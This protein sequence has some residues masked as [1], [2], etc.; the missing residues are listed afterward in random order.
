MSKFNQSLEERAR[1]LSAGFDSRNWDS[2]MPST[3]Q[4]EIALTLDHLT[5]QQLLHDQQ[6]K[7]LLRIECYVDTDLMQLERRIPR[8]TPYHFPEK[9][10]LK[11]RLFEIEN[12]RRDMTFRLEDR[13]QSLEDKLLSLINKHQQLDI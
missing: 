2:S 7:R 8:Y 10:K 4:R 3:I 6:M 1:R 11:K 9:E 12:Q 5:R 13:K